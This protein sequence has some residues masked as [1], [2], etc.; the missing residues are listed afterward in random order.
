MRDEFE[1]S[2]FLDG[3]PIP[4]NYFDILALFTEGMDSISE[5]DEYNDMY[6]DPILNRYRPIPSVEY[7][8]D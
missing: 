3:T 1:S 2:H 5:Q 4:D 8:G 7:D 6:F